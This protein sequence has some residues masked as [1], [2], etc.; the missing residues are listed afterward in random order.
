MIMNMEIT[1]IVRSSV[2]VFLFISFFTSCS[3]KQKKEASAEI[4]TY[5]MS[6][7]YSSIEEPL[8][9]HLDSHVYRI[10]YIPPV[11]SGLG[12]IVHLIRLVEVGSTDKVKIVE[13]KI[14]FRYFPEC[15]DE[16]RYYEVKKNVLNKKD[17]DM[18]CNSLVRNMKSKTKSVD[19]SEPLF[20]L[21]GFGSEDVLIGAW[22][23]PNEYN[24]LLRVRDTLSW[25]ILNTF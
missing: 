20:I 7:V 25:S 23:N 15:Y 22:Q 21:E 1:C 19:P 8:R 14:E 12:S 5:C 4:D 6:K 16:F 18:L 3:S 11:D 9:N 13:K 10:T 24:K 2:G 17:V